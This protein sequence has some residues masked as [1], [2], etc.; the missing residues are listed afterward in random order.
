MSTSGSEHLFPFWG[1]LEQRITVCSAFLFSRHL[2]SLSWTPTGQLRRKCLCWK[3]WWTVDLGTGENSVVQPISV[4]HGQFFL[5][6]PWISLLNSS[7]HIDCSVIY[8]GWDTNSAA[9][10]EGWSIRAC[11]HELLVFSFIKN[12]CVKSTELQNLQKQNW[13]FFGAYCCQK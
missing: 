3:L 4:S 2:T 12:N 9:K 7:V 11:F 1:G 10:V 8:S 6:F 5:S 13:E